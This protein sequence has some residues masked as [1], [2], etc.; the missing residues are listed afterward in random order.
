[1][2]T[3]WFAGSLG[4]LIVALAAARVWAWTWGATSADLEAVWPGDDLS[5]RASLVTTRAVTIEA[6]APVVWSWL[7]QIGQDRAGFYSYTWLENLARCAMPRVE[8]LVPEWQQRTLGERVWL[9]RRDRYRGE[10]RQIV[11]GID[12]GRALTM[13][14][15]VDWGRI[16]RRET[17]RGGTWTFIL[18]P[19]D[20]RRT[21]LVARSRG[22]EAPG[23]ALRLFYLALFAPIHF[24]ME[25]RML[26]RI[27]TLAEQTASARQAS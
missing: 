18:V 20:A 3:L 4:L 13:A 16:V 7:V 2:S 22:P 25:R 17:S 23:L 1:M 6:P 21:R 10:A 9:A 15:P 14:S 11:V 19:L 24:I 8:R 27:A 26:L 12:P 5:P